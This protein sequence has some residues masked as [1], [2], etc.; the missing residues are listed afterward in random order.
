MTAPSCWEL[1]FPPLQLS[2][3]DRAGSVSPQLAV[4]A[5]QQWVQGFPP[6]PPRRKLHGNVALEGREQSD[7]NH[8]VA[9]T[10]LTHLPPLLSPAGHG[11]QSRALLVHVPPLLLSWAEFLES[12]T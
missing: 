7:K 3:R 9:F 2:D 11:V 6:S 8:P 4:R 12:R 10:V 1:G 5:G